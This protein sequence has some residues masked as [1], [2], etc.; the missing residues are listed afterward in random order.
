MSVEFV[1]V[2]LVKFEDN[3]PRWPI[4][5]SGTQSGKAAHNWKKPPED[6]YSPTLSSGGEHLSFV[7][8]TSNNQHQ[9]HSPRSSDNQRHL[10]GYQLNQHQYS[11]SPTSYTPTRSSSHNYPQ[12]NIGAHF[13]NNVGS[14][15]AAAAFA[16]SVT[17]NKSSQCLKFKYFTTFFICTTCLALLSASLATHKW[18]VSKPMRI[19]RLNNGQTTTTNLTALMLTA[20]QETA[21]DDDRANNRHHH[22]QSSSLEHN[23]MLSANNNSNNNKQQ[24][25]LLQSSDPFVIPTTSVSGSISA[26]AIQITAPGQSS[27]FQGEIYFGLFNGVKVLNYGF[28]D[29]VSQLSGKSIV[30]HIG[31]T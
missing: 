23:K 18:L 3:N 25:Q 30:I 5:E 7:S 28:G 4:E 9:Q 8:S 2:K 19:L 11:V 16:V 12:T 24:H 6:M 27:K 17:S 26:P 10:N 13:A 22:H 29:R 21:A 31:L 15:A 1:D 20:T 14:A